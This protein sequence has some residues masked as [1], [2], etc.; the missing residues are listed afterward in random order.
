MIEGGVMSAASWC[1][2]VLSVA[3][4]ILGSHAAQAEARALVIGNSA[5]AH[6]DVLKNAATDATDVAEGLRRIGYD[7]TVGIDLDRRRLLDLVKS[8]T[9]IA[10]RAEVALFHYAG[11]AVQIGGE[12][13][14]M[15]IDVKADTEDEAK[16]QLIAVN[17]ILVD[18]ARSSKQR[19]IIL[20]ACRNNPFTAMGPAAS[21]SLG[22]TRGLAKVYDGIG[23]YVAF[24]TQ[25]GNVALDGAG[26]NSPFADALLRHM[27]TPGADVHAVMRRV[28]ADV[29]RA[30]NGTQIPWENSSLVADLSLARLGVTSPRPA[31][32]DPAPAARPP[33]TPRD[34]PSLHYVTGLDVNGDNFLA[35][36][37]APSGGGVRIA[38]MG[39]DTLLKV[40]GT[41]G[42]W[43]RVELL[44]GTTGWAHG[45]W[46][47]CCRSG[48]SVRQALQTVPPP[49][50]AAESCSDLWVRRNAI[51]KRYGYCFT[52]PRAQAY[53]GNAGCTRDLQAARAAM[54]AQDRA[55]VE[56]LQ[57]REQAMRCN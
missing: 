33:E 45:N 9:S 3:H 38:T 57:A 12:N 44:D 11:H 7:V 27:S 50:A 37:S 53:F 25:P 26:R 2:V 32:T 19:V 13:F 47:A 23:S 41:N 36:R 22:G 20:D 40:V 42:A 6:A 16:R 49:A 15:P 24:S 31:P 10:G 34:A 48:P 14:I 29:E 18:L 28:R 39:P 30:T 56:N 43:R 17:A 54:S 46:I 1:A 8:F 4:L 55:M 5:Y 51:W 35:L 21:R 52:T